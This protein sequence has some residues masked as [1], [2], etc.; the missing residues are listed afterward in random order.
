MRY[1]K[2]IAAGILLAIADGVSAEDL[3][4][5]Y[6][7]ALAQD[8]QLR[9]AVAHRQSVGQ[10]RNLA[11][12]RF[13]P[14]LSAQGEV[15]Q[16]RVESS[17]N[18]VTTSESYQSTSVGV[19]LAQPLLHLDA[20]AQSR[21]ADKSQLRGDA[22]LDAARQDLM[23]R[24]AEQYFGVLAA[25]DNLKFA[26]AEKT[27]IEKQLEQ[28]KQRFN[29]GL[30]AITDVHESQARFDLSVAREIDAENRLA[31]AYE[32]LREITGQYYKDLASLVADSP[33]LQAP[34]PAVVDHWVDLATQHNQQVLSSQWGR[35]I[36]RDE[37]ARQRAAHYP[38]FDL[39][40]RYAGRDDSDRAGGAAVDSTAV[41]LQMNWQLFEGGA[42]SAR[43]ERARQDAVVAE[44]GLEAAR[45]AV[46]RNARDTYLSVLA[47]ISRV[48]AYNQA[49]VSNK[50]ALDATEAGYEV[51]TRTTVDVLDA[52]TAL[53]QAQSNYSQARYD[54]ILSTIRLKRVIGEIAEEDLKQINSWLAQ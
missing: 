9:I 47:N 21:A 29:V 38:A 24:T 4:T 54:Y 17:V 31:N 49:V 1:Q 2:I 12:A 48:K 37:V 26:R 39:V 33:P 16:N 30:I 28:T 36:A 3:L 18:N 23:V 27:A 10:E 40:G 46:V 53:Y 32:A 34:Q 22:E 35:D 45:R 20:F 50:S 8:A 15:S 7:Q 52:R 13:L 41:S 14:S 11:T 5:V 44:G 42:A 6:Q 51:G 25:K 19:V 43:V